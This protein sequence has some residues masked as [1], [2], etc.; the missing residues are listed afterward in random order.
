MYSSVKSSGFYT[1]LAQLGL[2]QTGKLFVGFL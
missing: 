2:E 1:M